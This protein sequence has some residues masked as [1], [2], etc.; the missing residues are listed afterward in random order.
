MY[1]QKV[2][3]GFKNKKYISSI[4]QKVDT[5]YEVKI[6]QANKSTIFSRYYK[7]G[8]WQMTGEPLTVT[9]NKISNLPADLNDVWKTQYK[10]AT[11]ISAAK[12]TTPF[13]NTLY[14]IFFI[15]NNKKIRRH[16]MENGFAIDR[17]E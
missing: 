16:F 3:G 11:V 17:L 9:F 1:P 6:I 8:T 12:I 15:Q 7:N 13:N 2:G 10:T 5:V 14:E 4:W